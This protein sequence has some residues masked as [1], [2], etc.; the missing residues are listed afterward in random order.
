MG[1]SIWERLFKLEGKK[2]IKSD[3]RDWG[4]V[5]YKNDDALQWSRDHRV[6]GGRILLLIYLA[7]LIP[8]IIMDILFFTEAGIQPA[9]MV[10]LF[11]PSWFIFVQLYTNSI[12]HKADQLPVIYEQGILHSSAIS[13][14]LIRIFMPYT[15]LKHIV[16]KKEW[17]MLYLK[18]RRGKY[19]FRI[20]ELGEK[21]YEIRM[22]LFDGTYSEG[23]PPKLNVYT[24]GGHV[25]TNESGD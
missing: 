8:M 4:R 9:T 2:A 6:R 23:G 3:P 11:I 19:A 13:F 15:E 17:V 21:G 25:T 24:E 5:V 16:Q 12:H 14:Y 18:G 10:L 1:I 22:G 7:I 20:E